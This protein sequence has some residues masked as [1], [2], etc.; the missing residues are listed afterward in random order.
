MAYRH[1]GRPADLTVDPEEMLAAQRRST[2]KKLVGVGIAVVVLAGA[3]GASAVYVARKAR[4]EIQLAFDRTA[5]CLVGGAPTDAPGARVRNSQLVAMSVP[6]LKRSSPELGPWPGRCAA[7]T[8]ALA[9]AV[10]SGGGSAALAEAAEKLGKGVGLGDSVTAD[11]APL[12]DN[13]FKAAAAEKLTAA[14]AADVPPPPVPAQPMTLATLPKEARLFGGPL[15]LSSVFRQPFGDG[16][17]RFVVD[18][19]DFAWGPLACELTDG[20]H[21]ISCAK[22]PAPAAALSPAL[23]FWGTTSPKAKPFVFAGDRG[24]AGIFRSDT[25]ARVVDKLEYGAYGASALDDGSLGYLVW[26]DKPPATHF[27]RV[28]PDGARKESL[29]VARK[30]SGNPYYSSS[31]FWSYVAYKSVK[32]D[33]EG[34]RLVVREIEAAGTLGAPVDVGRIDEVGQIEGGE[35]EEPHLTACRSGDTTVIRAKGWRN[36]FITFLVAGKWTAP[37]EAPGLGGQLQCRP[38]E[39]IVSRVWGGTVGSGY[40]GGVDLRRCTVSGCDDRSVVVHKALGDNKDVLPR[41][42][43]DVKAVDVDGKVLLVWSAGDR[44][45]LRM[46]LAQPQELAGAADEVLYDDHIKDGAFRD[47]STMVGF[48]VWPTAHG[49]LLLIGT[50]AGVYAY[51]L[52]ANGKRTPATSAL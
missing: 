40:K 25:G 24:K 43:K 15:A 13:L 17:I 1:D 22:I 20:A 38:G 48:D 19:K 11:L 27:V 12:V 47:E 4:A 37:V 2:K 32:K 34:I 31:I 5:T 23:R 42:A 18:D 21:A 30:E 39:A 36:T 45:G 52:D 26:N 35:K 41:D 46:R 50:T 8:H 16:S 29:V 33:S 10:K 28:A 44:G 3:G 51:V 9:E 6:E 14:P 7:R 49:A